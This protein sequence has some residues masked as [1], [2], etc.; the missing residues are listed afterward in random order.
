[1][2]KLFSTQPSV[3]RSD[4]ERP[5]ATDKSRYGLARTWLMG[6]AKN[7]SLFDLAAIAHNIAK[8]AKFLSLYGLP[9]TEPTGQIRPK[10]KITPETQHYLRQIVNSLSSF[11]GF[12]PYWLSASSPG[13]Q[14][15]IIQ[16]TTPMYGIKH[17]SIVHPGQPKSLHLCAPTK[18]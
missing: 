6:L 18:I 11:S 8:G 5:F 2:Q 13:T 3:I 1:M 12:D 17:K 15:I 10:S 4:S 16:N 14:E 9:D 7:I